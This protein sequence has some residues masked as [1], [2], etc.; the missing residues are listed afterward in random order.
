MK[1]CFICQSVQVCEHREPEIL[2]I[3]DRN[4]QLFNK[5]FG[6]SK[7]EVTTETLR[8]RMAR[9]AINEAIKRGELKRPELCQWC[10]VTGR[11]DAHHTDYNRPLSVLWLCKHCHGIADVE[12]GS[13]KRLQHK[14]VESVDNSFRSSLLQ[15]GKQL[16]DRPLHWEDEY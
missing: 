9:A 2:C 5:M 3:R 15:S 10:G 13:R 12:I 6:K 14:A 1:A 7:P 4:R 8:R 11:I 16:V